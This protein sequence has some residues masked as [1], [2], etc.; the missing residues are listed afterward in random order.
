MPQSPALRHQARILALQAAGAAASGTTTQ[1]SQYELMLYQLAE[2]RRR[3]KLIKSVKSKIALKATLLPN[4]AAWIDGALSAGNG[5]QDDVVATIL[6]W[7][8]DVGQ[9]Q[10]ALSIARYVLTHN[11]TL[12][13]QY[14]RD[15]ATMLQDE[16]AVAFLNGE[17]A[18][19]PE[20]AASVLTDVSLLTTG[21][22]T[23]D[24][25]R[26]K[27]L[28]ALAYAQIAL[29]ERTAPEGKTQLTS[30]ELTLAIAANK[31]L[32]QALQL[33]DSVGVKKDIERLE[34]RIKKA[35]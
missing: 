35:A 24:Q 12:P 7:A 2:D 13:D 14:E 31:N 32:N 30:A 29:L 34:R 16:F 9:Y 21:K 4:Y 23:P 33:F 26:A 25:A 17:L 19:D 27:L 28:K 6:V 22:D 11:M 15:I 3:L 5:A 10:R 18:N 20:Q 1:G 8:I